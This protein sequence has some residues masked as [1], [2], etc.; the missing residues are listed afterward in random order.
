M[1]QRIT[2]LT[3]ALMA[4]LLTAACATDDKV[5]PGAGGDS[6]GDG[7]DY[8]GSGSDPE[9]DPG[10]GGGMD[11][12]DPDVNVQP[13]Y[14]TAHPRIYLG[15]NKARLQAALA[16][17]TA[18]AARFKQTVDNQ[19]GGANYWEFRAWN[20][21]LMGQLTGDPKYCTNAISQVDTFVTG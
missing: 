15:P 21:A 19:L 17:N 3:T 8:S 11:M 2:L 1:T 12:S 6:D 20:V 4:S 13:T 10:Y 9:M 16:A 14:P 18:A 5:D 7:S